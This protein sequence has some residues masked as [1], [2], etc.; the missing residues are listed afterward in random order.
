MIDNAIESAFCAAIKADSQM[1]SVNFFTALDDDVHKLPAITVVSKSESLAGSVIIYRS[2][3]EIRIENHATNTTPGEHAAIV[4]RVR[5]LLAARQ[6]MLTALNAGEAVQIVGYAVAGSSQDT[7]DE[8]FV[9]T[10][11]LK[12]GCRSLTN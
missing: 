4:S 1:G 5:S 12:A 7:T 2:D 9:T 3:V 6:E 11:N 10:I 8:K